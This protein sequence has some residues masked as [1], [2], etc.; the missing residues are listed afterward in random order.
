MT[1]GVVAAALAC[2]LVLSGCLGG[3]AGAPGA[4]TAETTE[5]A[6]PEATVTTDAV[7]TETTTAEATEM[8]TAEATETTTDALPRHRVYDTREA[9]AANA[10]FSVP[11]PN[12]SEPFE[13]D[14]GVAMELAEGRFVAM[15]YHDVENGS[16]E[17][18]LSIRKAENASNYDLT[19]GNATTVGDRDARFADGDGGKLLWECNGYFYRVSV[20]QFTE[21]FG[22]EELRAV[23]ESVGCE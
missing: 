3:S 17:N 6:T 19:V 5:P 2:L 22:E 9:L 11:D 12:V 21:E 4:T 7:T 16:L 23:A 14:G 20:Q 18:V 1:R 15:A 8:T 13:F 10:S